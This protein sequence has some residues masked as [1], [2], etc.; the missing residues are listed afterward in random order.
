MPE[1]WQWIGPG[2]RKFPKV[3]HHVRPVGA[4]VAGVAFTAREIGKAAPV[5]QRDAFPSQEEPP[6]EGRLVVP[7]TKGSYP[8]RY[9]RSPSTFSDSSLRPIFCVIWPLSNPRRL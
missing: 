6:E 2:P 9:L 5:W 4:N 3:S 8:R 1:S 7:K